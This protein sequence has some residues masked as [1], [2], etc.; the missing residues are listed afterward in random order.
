MCSSSS[1]SDGVA[2]PGGGYLNSGESFSS[3]SLILRDS[4]AATEAKKLNPVEVLSATVLPLPDVAVFA[5]E[6]SV[7]QSDIFKISLRSPV[8]SDLFRECVLLRRANADAIAVELVDVDNGGVCALVP[9]LGVGD[10]GWSVEMDD[11]LR[12]TDC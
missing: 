5:G 4:S 7:L 3:G 12:L 9:M 11:F 10:K 6:D 2:V 1:R 8:V